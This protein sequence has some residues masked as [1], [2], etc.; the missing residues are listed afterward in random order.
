[1]SAKRQQQQQRFGDYGED[2]A[3]YGEDMIPS[4]DTGASAARARMPIARNAETV[5][6]PRHFPITVTDLLAGA[7][8]HLTEKPGPQVPGNGCRREYGRERH[9]HRPDSG[10]R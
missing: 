7:A 2:R 8:R 6:P 1:V 3:D 9:G 4:F 10:D 5:A